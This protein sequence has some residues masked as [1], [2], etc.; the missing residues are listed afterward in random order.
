MIIAPIRVSKVRA[1]SSLSLIGLGTNLRIVLCLKIVIKLVPNLI[2][3]S[4]CDY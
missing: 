2:K 4:A 3:L 1:L